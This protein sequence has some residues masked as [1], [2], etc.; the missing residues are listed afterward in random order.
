M[1]QTS[2]DRFIQESQPRSNPSLG[3]CEIMKKDNANKTSFQFTKKKN[4]RFFN[5]S[6]YFDLAQQKLHTRIE[7][8][9]TFICFLFKLMFNK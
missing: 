1:F 3:L 5:F 2:T 4:F 8:A 7:F 6:F 9:Q